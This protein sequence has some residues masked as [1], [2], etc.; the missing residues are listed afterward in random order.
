M[1]FLNNTRSGPWDYNYNA[2]EVTQPVLR[3]AVMEVAVW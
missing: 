1:Q 2:T 3:D